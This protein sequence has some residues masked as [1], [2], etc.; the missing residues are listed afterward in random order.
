[1][2]TAEHIVQ[3]DRRI[4]ELQTQMNEM[5]DFFVYQSQAHDRRME[6]MQAQ[7]NDFM[8]KQSLTQ[9]RRM[10]ELHAQIDALMNQSPKG[11]SSSSATS[12]VCVD[13]LEAS[14]HV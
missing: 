11:H 10:D 5:N 7:M 9:D 12:L 6:D 13:Q 8:V 14:V 2:T 4:E 3:L 1:M